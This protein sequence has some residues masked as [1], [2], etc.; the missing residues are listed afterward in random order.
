MIEAPRHLIDLGGGHVRV[1]RLAAHAEH[2]YPLHYTAHLGQPGCCH[3]CGCTDRY[4]CPEGC[5]WVN[6][7]NTL[8]S[9][10]LERHLLP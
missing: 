9:R 5:S 7:R 1:L 3:V 8:C 6:R 10:C 4:A 2:I